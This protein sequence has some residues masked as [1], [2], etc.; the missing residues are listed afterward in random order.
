MFPEDKKYPSTPTPL[1]SGLDIPPA[2]EPETWPEP[3]AEVVPVADTPAAESETP[4]AVKP[5]SSA[6]SAKRMAAKE[7]KSVAPRRSTKAVAK[8][9][10]K[11]VKA[12]KV[13]KAPK[14]AKV[15]RI[16][17]S[18]KLP[19]GVTIED[20]YASLRKKEVPEGW[21]TLAS[22]IK[23]AKAKK[24]ISAYRFV[25]VIGGDRMLSKPFSKEFKVILVGHTRY[26]SKECLARLDD[27][28]KK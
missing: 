1:S 13:A 21:I 27:I 15:T 20:H 26:I 17:P 6:V 22:A 28:V 8:K 12:A 9:S 4:A 10:G 19:D 16:A 2:P 7:K 11:A 3:V 23:T 25:Q 14:V 5:S 18:K 24:N